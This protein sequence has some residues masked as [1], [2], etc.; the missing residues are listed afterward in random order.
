MGDGKRHGRPTLRPQ[1]PEAARRPATLLPVSRIAIATTA[2]TSPYPDEEAPLLARAVSAAGHQAETVAWDAALDWAAYDLVVVRSP[3]DYFERLNEFLGW[4]DRVA[5]ASRIINP[6]NVIRWNSHKGYLA[7]LGDG[8]VPVLPTLTLPLGA[9]DPVASLAGTGW[10]DVVLKPAVDGGARKALRAP[11]SSAHARAHL[12]SLVA[13]GDVIVQPYA[14]GIEAGE[15]SL[16]YF[17][18]EFSHAVRKV[19]AAGDYR[20]Q[21]FHGGTEHPHQPSAAELDVAARA[22]S[23][24]P[25]ELAYARVDLIDVDGQ[26]TLMELEL[27]EPDLF[28]RSD[29]GAQERF[30]SVI[31]R[32][33]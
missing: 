23:L 17:G 12:E 1:P 4:V 6:A 29:T 21:F 16:L 18:G 10:D 26:P 22:L 7:E 24:A 15:V 31:S 8:G 27:I 5:S 9:H 14:A 19:P 11:A 25:G 32:S 28:F 33:A 30:A 2:P 3:W 20:V 13:A